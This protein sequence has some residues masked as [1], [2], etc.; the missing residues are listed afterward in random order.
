MKNNEVISEHRMTRT[1]YTPELSDVGYIYISSCYICIACAVFHS[2]IYHT[3]SQ[4][5]QKIIHT[6]TSS[7]LHCSHHIT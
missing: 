4:T 1:P 6:L 3:M 7:R 5:F 2:L